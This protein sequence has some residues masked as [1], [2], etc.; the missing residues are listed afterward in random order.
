MNEKQEEECPK[1]QDS[2]PNNPTDCAKRDHSSKKHKCTDYQEEI[3]VWCDDCC[4]FICWNC[5]T[6]HNRHRLTTVDGLT[7][8]LEP[9]VRSITFKTME[10]CSAAYRSI[11]DMMFYPREKIK[12]EK[13]R[14]GQ[15]EQENASHGVE[16]GQQTNK[17]GH[18]RNRFETMLQ[19]YEEMKPRIK[20][21]ESRVKDLYKN[22]VSED[23]YLMTTLVLEAMEVKYEFDNF[24]ESL[25]QCLGEHWVMVKKEVEK[26]GEYM[27]RRDWWSCSV[28]ITK[29]DTYV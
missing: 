13:K 18:E 15:H 20:D 19:K 17:N 24:K 27:V 12:R 5:L 11:D 2:S 10:M 28:G 6:D 4:N 16:L 3:K 26:D 22:L 23:P 29:C 7:G 21:L 1:R 14:I 8:Y 25:D 9:Y